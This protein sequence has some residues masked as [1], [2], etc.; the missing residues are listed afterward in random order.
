MTPKTASF[1]LFA[2]LFIGGHFLGRGAATGETLFVVAGSFI[3]AIS[4]ATLIWVNNR[5]A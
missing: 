4:L 2:P 5:R 1:F 3:L